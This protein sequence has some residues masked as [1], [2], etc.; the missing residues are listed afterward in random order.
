MNAPY[1]QKN[2]K[3][4]AEPRSS[5]IGLLG[6]LAILALVAPIIACSTVTPVPGGP[7]PNI[8]ATVEAKLAHERAVDATVESRLEQEQEIQATEEAKSNPKPATQPTDIPVP[9][10]TPEPTPTPY[11][12]P[13]PVPTATPFFV[14]IHPTKTPTPTPKP[15]MVV[16]AG[17]HYQKAEELMD[18]ELWNAALR[19]YHL[20]IALNPRHADAYAGRAIAKNN[21]TLISIKDCY[22]LRRNSHSP[23]GEDL[24]KAIELDS[25]NPR[26]YK[27]RGLIGGGEAAGSIY[28]RALVDYNTAIL[29]DPLDAE[30]YK[31]RG[32]FYSRC[33][34]FWFEG[35][36]RNTDHELAVQDY[37]KAISLDQT[38][39][40]AYMMRAIS[41]FY[42]FSDE[43]AVSD[44]NF[45]IYLKPD[46]A[47]AYINRAS[48][49]K[50]MGSLKQAQADKAKACSLDWIWCNKT[51]DEPL[52]PTCSMDVEYCTRFPRR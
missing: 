4:N 43:M 34:W 36:Q 29:L 44:Y 50:R 35:Y 2:S 13:T 33:D 18:A 27:M 26:Y 48:S 30:T 12:S 37:S 3:G 32:D 41:Y 21:G 49:Y 16:T 8:D 15:T 23:S 1:T 39:A 14:T 22:N 7:T 24:D 28:S 11:A 40:A 46:W 6:I 5:P 31:L 17:D 38:Y 25:I 42:L 47:K 10:D 45:A 51:Y 19:Q 20:A 52:V 9:T